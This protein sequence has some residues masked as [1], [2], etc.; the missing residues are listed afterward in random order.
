[1]IRGRASIPAV[2]TAGGTARVRVVAA[3]PGRWQR[4][5]ARIAGVRLRTTALPDS[6]YEARLDPRA[7]R[8]AGDWELSIAVRAGGLSRR[9]SRFA[10]EAP[11]A[12]AAVT[13]PAPDGALLTVAGTQ[14]GKLVARVREQWMTISAARTGD[15]GELV[16]SGDLRLDAPGALELRRETDSLTVTA[17]VRVDGASWTARVPPGDLP[18]GDEPETVW[19]LWAVAG[20]RRIPLS[21]RGDAA[22]PLTRTRQGEAALVAD[23]ARA[24][25]HAART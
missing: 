21:L 1:M 6:A 2:A 9:R 7:L 8:G 18:A 16:L 3:R 4:V 10:I 24:G 17:A 5:R 12:A 14:W 23:A 25:S 19:E 13:V 22:A 20:S 11:R 15:D